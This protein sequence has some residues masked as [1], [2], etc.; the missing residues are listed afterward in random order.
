MSF[1]EVDNLPLYSATALSGEPNSVSF[2]SLATIERF[3]QTGTKSLFEL[4]SNQ[5][6]Q[7]VGSLATLAQI[8]LDPEPKVIQA[9][10]SDLNLKKVGIQIRAMDRMR[11]LSLKDRFSILVFT[12]WHELSN[13]RQGIHENNT[14]VNGKIQQILGINEGTY[15]SSLQALDAENG[16][17]AER[18]ARFIGWTNQL[19]ELTEKR[20]GFSTHE[21]KFGEVDY[22]LITIFNDEKY[23]RYT[24]DDFA[25][26]A[27]KAG[28]NTNEWKHSILI[29]KL[30]NERRRLIRNKL[31]A[32][33]RGE[34]LTLR[35]KAGQK[36][37]LAHIAK[38]ITDPS[39]L[40]EL[41]DVSLTEIYD[42]QMEL[43]IL[44]SRVSKAIGQ[45]Q[46]L[47]YL[48]QG[49]KS[50]RKLGK[51]IGVSRETILV[52]EKEMGIFVSTREKQHQ[53]RRHIAKSTTDPNE[54]AKLLGTHPDTIRR[55][56]KLP[57]AEST[58]S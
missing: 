38:G 32:K 16:K 56:R 33:T 14:A 31:L 50:P 5:R 55:W 3:Q 21:S 27:Q 28:I 54:L 10:L 57:E 41:V 40:A 15:L 45:P 46:L 22:W 6:L 9:E 11:D 26:L 13:S 48:R 53:M 47:S 44:P 25:R 35:I 29:Q 8:T 7:T 43:G 12:L 23:D 20:P 18:T 52:W 30:K 58:N 34:R 1:L 42:W 2:L 37:M 51:L 17:L 49:I 36:E 24:W 4:F 19:L 39:E